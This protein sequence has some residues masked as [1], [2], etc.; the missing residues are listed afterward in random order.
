[1]NHLCGLETCFSFERSPLSGYSFEF[2][3]TC[4]NT[5]CLVMNKEEDD[6]VRD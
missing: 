6:L 5:S 2:D 4:N 1:M 3:M